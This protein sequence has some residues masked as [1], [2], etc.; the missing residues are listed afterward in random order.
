MGLCDWKVPFK[1]L[2]P[3]PVGIRQGGWSNMSCPEVTPIHPLEKLP[4]RR[5]QRMK[6]GMCGRG[7][8]AACWPRRFWEFQIRTYPT[9]PIVLMCSDSECTVPC[10]SVCNYSYEVQPDGNKESTRVNGGLPRLAGSGLTHGTACSEL[11]V[12]ESYLT[13]LPYH[14]EYGAQSTEHRVYL[15]TRNTTTPTTSTTLQP[16]LNS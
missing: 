11:V 4:G 2:A 15:D 9:R 14:T 13:I 3:S 16:P 5:T 6:D 12:L 7:G 10:S 1:D 8:E